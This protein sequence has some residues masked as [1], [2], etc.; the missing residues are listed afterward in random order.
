MTNNLL[1]VYSG[2]VV[3]TGQTFNDSCIQICQYTDTVSD[4]IEKLVDVFCSNINNGKIKVT[5]Q[6]QCADF[7]STK[8]TSNDSSVGM[9]INTDAN[10]CKSIDFTVPSL[11][12]LTAV[13]LYNNNSVVTRTS[14]ND[15]QSYTSPANTL[16]ANGDQ[17]IIDNY[18]NGTMNLGVSSVFSIYFG[19]SQLFTSSPIGNSN[20]ATRTTVTINKI[21]RAHV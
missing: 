1:T 4:V 3:Y 10:G 8:L 13:I 5:S 17:L 2:N 7:L 19:T 16:G 21:G 11:P 20:G 6:D 12:S 9:S 14:A 15:F 18:I